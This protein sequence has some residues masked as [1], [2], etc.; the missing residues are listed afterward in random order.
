MLQAEDSFASAGHPDVWH[1][2]ALV[3]S[4]V[5]EGRHGKAAN[6]FT[7]IGFRNPPPVTRVYV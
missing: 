1:N 7:I 3:V 2:L 6:I 5:Q 4:I